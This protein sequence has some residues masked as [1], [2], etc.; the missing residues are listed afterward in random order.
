MSLAPSD[1]LTSAAVL[2][3]RVAL[4]PHSSTNLKL[5]PT[6]D[7]PQPLP[8]RHPTRRFDPA[9]SKVTAE[10]GLSRPESR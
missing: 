4:R 10:V 1:P 9:M 6:S 7:R 5:T 2:K 3:V 8:S